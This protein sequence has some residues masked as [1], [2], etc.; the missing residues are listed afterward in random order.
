MN[1]SI[2][3]NTIGMEYPTYFI[4]D[5]AANHDGSLERAKELIFLAAEAGANAAK[6]QNFI[7][8][9]IVSNYGFA[10]LDTGLGHQSKWKKS[11][12]EVYR[13]AS[14]PIEWT[15]ELK[16]SCLE[17]KID[18]FTT[19]YDLGLV[20]YLSEHVCAWKLGSGDITWHEMISKLASDD[21][22]L[23]LA[24]G[25]T[26]MNEVVLAM[27]VANKETD[28][29]V[30]M[31]CNT[32]YT[33]NIDNISYSALNVLKTYKKFFP[34]T[35]LGLSDHT[36]GDMTVLGAVS[37]GARVI[38]KHFTDD[39]NREGPDHLFAMDPKS[40]SLMVERTRWL[41]AALGSHEKTIMPNELE[42]VVVQRRAIRTAKNLT[43]GSI[44]KPEDLVVLRP[45]PKDA[46]EPY[47]IH[48][49]IGQRLTR[50]IP[51]GDCVRSKDIE[52]P[53]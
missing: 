22:P 6:F 25:A 36:P 41:E 45:C 24:T 29:L 39:N 52:C 2:G 14:L 4:A 3:K 48:T 13:E 49:L 47:K 33:G 12:V 8:E 17:A 53:K 44:I 46:L 42:T 21:K 10:N 23:L 18:Y 28:K 38:E 35:V 27:D 5:I 7:A 30:L 51:E 15:E 37:L 31:Q 34:N 1:I 40:W 20:D 26:T 43:A 32:N 16:K 50:D 19:P 11:V 9:T